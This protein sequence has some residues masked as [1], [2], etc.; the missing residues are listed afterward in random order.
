MPKKTSISSLPVF[1]AS[2]LSGAYILYVGWLYDFNPLP[3]ISIALMAFG[4]VFINTSKYSQKIIYQTNH[5]RYGVYTML[6]CYLAINLYILFVDES[7]VRQFVAFINMEDFGDPVPKSMHTYEENCDLNWENLYDNLDHYFVVHT[8]G[9]FLIMLSVKDF[10]L[11]A[12][13]G[14]VDELIEVTFKYILPHLGECWFDS[15]FL[16]LIVSNLG[17]MLLAYVILNYNRVPLANFMGTPSLRSSFLKFLNVREWKVYT[18]ARRFIFVNLMVINQ[19]LY[20]S[21]TFFYM[22]SLW[23]APKS[24]YAIFRGTAHIIVY[25]LFINEG[26]RYIKKGKKASIFELKSLFCSCAVHLV[27]SIIAVKYGAKSDNYADEPAINKKMAV[28]WMVYLIWF[29]TT[30]RRMIKMKKV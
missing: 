1:I 9:W 28:F 14:L 13:L 30:A 22:N 5:L 12:L 4:F 2:I 18:D 27:E 15:W 21:A 25:F 26:D 8:L 20:M 7:K 3:T 17:G 29:I 19:A 23:I 24:N 6:L 10:K 16:D 11:L